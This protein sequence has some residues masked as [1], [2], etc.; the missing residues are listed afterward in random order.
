[1]RNIAYDNFTETA[2]RAY[3]GAG[4]RRTGDILQL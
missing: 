4:D 2:V 1:M 3:A